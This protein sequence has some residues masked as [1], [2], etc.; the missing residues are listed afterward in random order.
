MSRATVA[1]LFARAD[2]V[3]H[4]LPGCDVWTVE[5]DARLWPGGCP[6]V[7]H[8]PCRAWGQLK[9]FAKPAE[10]EKELAVWA[11]EQVRQWGGVLEH[12]VLSGLWPA[13]G[14]PECGARDE[15]G[16]FTLPVH[17]HWWGHKARKGTRLY[18]V[19]CGP[20][21]VPLMPMTLAEP[22]HVM[23][24]L[25]KGSWHGT[26]KPEIPKREREA[27]PHLFAE[28]LVDLARCCA[29]VVP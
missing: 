19:G 25:W 13:M 4:S 27:T 2:S 16:G 28:W 21:D 20:R 29:P 15:H 6:V 10:G 11:V 26:G 7:A 23:G 3:Y 22:T 9:H 24:K 14:L 1:I 18:V 12:P 8:P 5:R 17:Q